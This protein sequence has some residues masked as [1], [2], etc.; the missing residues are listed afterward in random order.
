MGYIVW[1][2]GTGENI[3]LLHIRTTKKKH[4]YGKRLFCLMLRDLKYNQPYHS[5]FGFTNVGND[6][7]KKF[8]AAIGFELET[9]NGVYAAGSCIL[10]WA[11]YK[12]LLEKNI[13]GIGNGPST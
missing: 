9:V 2:L 8:Y 7:A 4:G 5:I 12:H 6:E 13:Y 11:S 10:F 1:R 3:E